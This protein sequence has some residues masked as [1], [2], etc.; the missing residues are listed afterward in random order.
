MPST[1]FD[2]LKLSLS[3]VAPATIARRTVAADRSQKTTLLERAG[4]GEPT[5]E[6]SSGPIS[7]A[8]EE[9]GVTAS[10]PNSVSTGKHF[11]GEIGCR[12]DVF[13]GSR[14]NSFHGPRSR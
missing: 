6:S 7:G 5:A 11:V 3:Q 9:L 13:A 8:G 1:A 2:R 12:D 4:T 10:L 14:G